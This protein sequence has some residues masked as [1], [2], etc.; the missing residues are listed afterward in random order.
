MGLSRISNLTKYKHLI[1][2][3]KK[4]YNDV[5]FINLS[6]GALGVFG[7]ECKSYLE[8]LDSLGFDDKHKK[9]FIRKIMALSIR[10]TYYVFCCGNNEWTNPHLLNY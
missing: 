2:K 5:K 8:M 10:S 1:N 3:Q 4:C 7:K 9:Y 6:I